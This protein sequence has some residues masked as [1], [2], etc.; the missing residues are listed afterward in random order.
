MNEFSSVS[1]VLD[2]LVPVHEQEEPAWDDVLARAERLETASVFES[3]RPQ[4]TNGAAPMGAGAVSSVAKRGRW[5]TRRRLVAAA[6][7]AALLAVLFATPAFGLLLDLI[8]RT[9]VPFAG[10][11][12]P[13]EVKRD[14]F[15][16]SLGLPP[17]IAPQAIASQTR[18]VGSF[19]TGDKTRVLWVAPTRDGGYCYRF[20]PGFIG[21]RSKK[22]RTRAEPKHEPPGYVHGQLLGVTFQDGGRVPAQYLT[23]LGGDLLAPT[24]YSLT[25]IFA[26]GSKTPLRF[27][28]VSKPIDAGFFYTQIPAG[29]TTTQTRA[30]AVELRDKNGKLLA[31]QPF[32]YLT[33]AQLARERARIKAMIN[34]FR[35]QR[36]PNPAIH[37]SPALPAPSAPQQHGQADGV[38]VVAGANGVV[39]FDTSGADAVVRSLIAGRQVGYGCLVKVPYHSEPVDLLTARTTVAHVSVWVQGGGVHPPFLG[40]EIQGSYGHTW[41]DRL[42]GHSAV[43]VAF[44]PAGAR[45]FADRAAARDLALFVRSKAMHQIRKLTGQPLQDELHRRYGAAIAQFQPPSPPLPAGR[46]G[47]VING[48]TLTFIERSTTGRQFYVRIVNGHINAENVKPLAFVF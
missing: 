37:P 16:L 12:A 33:A 44:T 14:F 19:R 18:K 7:V 32:A 5:W 8:G 6:I 41:P 22:D 23:Q 31:R 10:R 20:D 38:S 24:A 9:N 4:A 34:R 39:D 46:I 25:V 26:D 28:Y 47:Y 29:H 40:C 36:R 11:S 45:L 27:Y 21:C 35:N 15:D 42:H 3:V 1:A 48:N 13:L 30:V 17:G 43:E 2:E